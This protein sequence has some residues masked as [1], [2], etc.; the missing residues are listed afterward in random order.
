MVGNT[1]WAKFYNDLIR[2]QFIPKYFNQN[3]TYFRQ[4]YQECLKQNI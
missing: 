4:I 2:L 1:T 3:D